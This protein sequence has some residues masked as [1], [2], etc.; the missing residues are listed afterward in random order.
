MSSATPQSVKE[1]SA[2]I[3]PIEG[4]EVFY[5]KAQV[6]NRDLSILAL[7][8]FTKLYRPEG[9][10]V[11]EGLAASGLRSIRY[12]QEVHKLKRVVANDLE[13]TAVKHMSL[14]RA[15]NGIPGSLMAVSQ[16]DACGYM[17]T[18][19]N[20]FDVIDLD[21]YGSAAPFL[22]AAVRSVRSGGLLCVTCTDS[23]V[24]CGNHPE[25][26]FQR[27]GG[28]AVKARFCHEASIRL[29]LS[30]IAQAAGKVKRS[31]TPLASFSIDFYYRVFVKIDDNPA[32]AVNGILKTGMVLK[33][34]NCEAHSLTNLGFRGTSRASRNKDGD[35][36]STGPI[37]PGRLPTS[38][39]CSECESPFSIGGPLWTGPIFTESF[40]DACIAE[41]D[42]QPEYPYLTVWDK[43][44]AL[45]FGLRQELVDVPLFYSFPSLMGNVKSNECK[46]KQFRSQ[47]IRLG[48]R[49]S[50][51]HRD[52]SA[53]KTD[54]PQS[55]VFDI[56]RL[57]ARKAGARPKD[58]AAQKILNKQVDQNVSDVVDF[59]MI[60]EENAKRVVPM[61]LPNPEANWG[62]KKAAKRSKL[63]H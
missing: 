4:N 29:M 47:I 27:Y 34:V 7:N 21:P 24:L 15:H 57:W 14:N 62:P 28:V 8:T 22:D 18:H 6:F 44:R 42:N 59:D 41:T 1:G 9:L 20:E 50:H 33:C 53:I 43:M 55:V 5:N 40:V 13:A 54:A 60:V 16:A 48:Y 52:P 26:C 38:G 45:L 56:L 32:E 51:S 10:S 49:V 63:E 3:L 37:K 23:L 11:F 46:L 61:F 31:M 2:E 25:T 19:M 58:I 39:I 17:Y 36:S 35:A 12:S 30:S